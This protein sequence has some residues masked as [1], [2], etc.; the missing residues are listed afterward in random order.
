MD[1]NIELKLREMERAVEKETITS[2]IAPSSQEKRAKIND[3]VNHFV[4]QKSDEFQN[5][6]KRFIGLFES[7][8]EGQV[9]G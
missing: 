5:K 9:N 6:L 2:I 4:R 3:F 1:R 7:E 8:N